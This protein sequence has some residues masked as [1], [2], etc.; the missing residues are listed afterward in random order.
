MQKIKLVT[1]N[2]PKRR[3]VMITI[4]EEKKGVKGDQL[5]LS[6]NRGRWQDLRAHNELMVR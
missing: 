5:Q 1:K 3:R 6:Q 4:S 2:R